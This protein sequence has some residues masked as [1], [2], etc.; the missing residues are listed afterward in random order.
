MYHNAQQTVHLL[1]LP[2]EISDIVNSFLFYSIETVVK[3]NKKEIVKKIKHAYHSRKN[4][5]INY[6]TQ[7]D[8]DTEEHWSFMAFCPYEYEVQFQAFNCKHCGNYKI[9]DTIEIS[10]NAIC[11]CK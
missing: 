4:N 2:F 5:D 1:P 9:T 7:E 10:K 11:V 3:Q 6:I 8:P